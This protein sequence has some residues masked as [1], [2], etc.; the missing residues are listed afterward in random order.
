MPPVA[1]IKNFDIF[2]DAL[3]GLCPC[4]V[5][6][7]IN[8]FCFECVEER[9]HHSVIITI[10]LSAHA[11]WCWSRILR[12]ACAAYW[13]PRSEW[14]TT[15]GSGLRLPKACWNAWSTRF[16]V[17]LSSMDHPIIWR[18]Y[19]SRTA[20]RYSQPSRVRIYVIS[21]SQTLLGRSVLNRR[22][23]R[24][25]ATGSLWS[26]WVVTRNLRFVLA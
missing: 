16:W 11:L 4:S 20:E 10:A 15:P 6:F 21:E 7:K 12:K 8:D 19:K 18:L 24:F 14:N 1:I 13:L 25:S 9:F 2:K 22:L 17:S 3:P 26:L 5:S 23:I